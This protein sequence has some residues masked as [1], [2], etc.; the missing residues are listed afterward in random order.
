[1]GEYNGDGEFTEALV[2]IKMVDNITTR[3]EQTLILKN[4][5][6]YSKY[7]FEY[8]GN[9]KITYYV[10]NNNAYLKIDFSD[11]T[12]DDV[13]PTLPNSFQIWVDGIYKEVKYI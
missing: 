5:K 4:N 10:E 7:S 13:Y 9:I 8:L 2:K 12:T 6:E 11:L 1:L 3:F